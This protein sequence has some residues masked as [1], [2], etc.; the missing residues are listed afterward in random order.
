MTNA[1]QDRGD[2]CA[3]TCPAGGS[4]VEAST[5]R[6]E[7]RGALWDEAR[8]TDPH[9]Q[10]DKAARV[11]RMFDAIAPTYERVNRV[12]SAG[13]DARW[14]RRAVALADVRSD[15]RV[16]DVACGTGDLARLFAASGPAL[17]VGID[18]AANMLRLAAARGAARLAWAQ[19]DALRL[20]FADACFSV[21]GCAFGV[22]NFCDLAAGLAE[23]HRVLRRGGRAVIV[24][25]GLPTG[26]L[27]R[28]AY[29]LYFEHI[30]PRL[31]AALSGDRNGAYRY[32]PKS[33]M[34][35]PDPA[36]LARALR[37]AGFADVQTAP[38][39]AGI[40]VAYLARKGP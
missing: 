20:P 19:G 31:G 12:A 6:A 24:E 38:M 36:G 23:M 27:R 28:R 17:V 16:L 10:P 26:R 4:D 14:R 9:G 29:R 1:A 5:A 30:L 40:A 18:F 8:L 32:L 34:S 7:P 39:T 22:R 37:S 25:F 11:R 33:V 15:D 13:R 21:V 2:A 3:T 35:F